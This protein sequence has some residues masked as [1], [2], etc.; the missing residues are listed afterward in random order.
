LKFFQS[1]AVIETITYDPYGK[2][3]AG[4]T[5]SKFQYTGQEKDSETGLNYYDSRYYSSDIRRFSQPDDIIQ[6][7]YDPQ[8]LNRYSYVNNNPLRYTDP[9]GHA[10][11]FANGK[12]T[13]TL[14]S[15]T[16]QKKTS[17]TYQS[18][19]QTVTNTANTQNQQTNNNSGAVAGASTSGTNNN[20]NSSSNILTLKQNAQ[21]ASQHRISIF[22]SYPI[23]IYHS[24]WFANK[25]REGGDWDYKHK[26][27]DLADFGNFNYGLTGREAGYSTE[28]LQRMGGTVQQLTNLST[29]VTGY[30]IVKTKNMP[31]SGYPYGDSFENGRSVDQEMIK[32]GA[33]SYMNPW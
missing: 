32:R 26:D 22:N 33:D 30:G 29:P 18:F 9:T 13:S 4:G 20:S 21:E 31:W 2:V 27:P 5:L 14:I 17:Q 16:Q 15:T 7:V 6:N 11:V 8:S 19:V 23:N 25:V 10:I 12:I 3:K 28:V 24:L 1:G